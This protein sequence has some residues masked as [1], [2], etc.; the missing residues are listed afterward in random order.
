MTSPNRTQSG[1][2]EALT[3]RLRHR[4]EAMGGAV[5]DWELN[6]KLFL[7]AAD[8]L[9]ALSANERAGEKHDS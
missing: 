4:A 2:V 9:D 3:K 6:K 5:F 7:D 8:M 1:L